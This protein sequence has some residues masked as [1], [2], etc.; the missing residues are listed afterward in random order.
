MTLNVVPK[1]S[2]QLF[3]FSFLELD[4]CGCL[5]LVFVWKRAIR[6]FFKISSGEV[7]NDSNHD[8]VISYK[9]KLQKIK[10]NV[11]VETITVIF[12]FNA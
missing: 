9:E 4:G 1:L 2:Q 12:N 3:F 7:N 5:L 8:D 6:R 11:A 10:V